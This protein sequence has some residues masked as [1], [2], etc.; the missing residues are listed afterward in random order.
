MDVEVE[1]ERIDSIACE[2]FLQKIRLDT[3]L[4][5]RAHDDVSNA[6]K[7][8]SMGSSRRPSQRASPNRLQNDQA[9]RRGEYSTDPALPKW[10]N[11]SLS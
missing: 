5:P 1:L 7:Y 3:P 4:R 9:W 10:S 8:G 2:L 6:T 11:L